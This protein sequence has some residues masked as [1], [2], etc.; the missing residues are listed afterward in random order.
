MVVGRQSL[1][2]LLLIGTCLL[3]TLITLQ[4]T[5]MSPTKVLLKTSFLVPF[6]GYVIVPWRVNASRA[7]NIL[8]L[9][10]KISCQVGD[11]RP[12]TQGKFSPDA[13]LFCTSSWHLDALV[14]GNGSQSQWGWSWLLVNGYIYVYLDENN[15]VWTPWYVPLGKLEVWR[16]TNEQ[17]LQKKTH[18]WVLWCHDVFDVYFSR[19]RIKGQ[20]EVSLGTWIGRELA[21]NWIHRYTADLLCNSIAY[22][23]RLLFFLMFF[24][25]LALAAWI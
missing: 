22:S 16:Y 24:C 2:F 13:Q 8:Q 10:L 11:E 18:P 9:P 6:V 15:K 20:I 5:N 23:E 7:F 3:I 14:G 25:F 21:C 4:G 19:D 1:T 17:N 12:L